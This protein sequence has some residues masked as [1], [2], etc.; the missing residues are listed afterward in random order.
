MM[1][2]S[3]ISPKMFDNPFLDFF[4]RTHWLVVPALWL[5]IAAALVWGATTYGT[6]WWVIATSFAGGLVAWSLAE[7]WLHRTLFHWEPQTSWG[8]FFHFMIHGVHHKWHK[9][10]YRL[11]MPPAVSLVLGAIFFAVFQGLGLLGTLAGVAMG[12]HLAGFAGFVVGYVTYDCTHY[13]LHHFK[14]RTTYM[15]RLRAHH[16]NH[17]HNDPDHKFGVSSMVWDRVF[18]TV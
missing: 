8:P 12:W 3:D 17:H 11:V 9:D 4:S 10:P 5:P 16:M 7:Y 6:A 13:M 18:G 14:P 2:A 15:K 1:R